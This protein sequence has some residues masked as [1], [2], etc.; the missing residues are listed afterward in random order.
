MSTRLSS[1]LIA[2]VV[3]TR[4]VASAIEEKLQPELLPS[5][6]TC[7]DVCCKSAQLA[8]TI[9]WQASKCELATQ[10]VNKCPYKF[11]CDNYDTVDGV[12]ANCT[13]PKSEV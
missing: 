9:G 13:Q 8:P 6:S 11:C 12:A 10:C 2:L 7:T 3:M 5:T 1:F 4:V